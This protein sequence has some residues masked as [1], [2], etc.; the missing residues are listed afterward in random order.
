MNIALIF[1]GGV[2]ARFG[3]SIPKQFLEI[4]NVPILI[5][6]LYQFES[7]EEIDKIVVV[8]KSDWID[9]LKEQLVKFNITKVDMILEGQQTAFD[10]IFE[11]V[12]Y[13]HKTFN[14][15]TFILVHD[16]VRPLISKE[17]IINNIDVAKK[18]GNCICYS[19]AIETVYCDEILDRSKCKLLRAPQTFVSKDLYNA[20]L[21]AKQL[22]MSFI[23]CASMMIFFNT[24]LFFSECNS[25]NIKVTTDIDYKIC[26]LYLE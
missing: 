15:E 4:K 7:V 12:K 14:E 11:G 24:Q 19:K 25:N 6:T 22:D 2:G 3:A 26:K 9:Y 1:A 20:F 8:C 13:I 10:S 21:K 5:Y 16:G 17:S 23:D 18:H